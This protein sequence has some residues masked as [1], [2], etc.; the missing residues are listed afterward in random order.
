[1]GKVMVIDDDAT[2]CK[3]VSVHLARAGHEVTSVDDG[4][5]ATRLVARG[6]VD[7]ILLDLNMPKMNGEVFL[8]VLRTDAQRRATP[9][10]IVS[11]AIGSEQFK[12]AEALGIQGAV[13]KK[14][15]KYPE[16]TRLVDSF[17]NGK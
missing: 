13:D 11:A 16:L 3:L 2:Y 10:I 8:E 7:L 14:T 12:R 15:L 4:A 5:T 9:V 6:M 17:L 1:M